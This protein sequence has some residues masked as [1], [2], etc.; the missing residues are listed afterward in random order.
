MADTYYPTLFCLITGLLSTTLMGTY[1]LTAG[2]FDAYTAMIV[3]GALLFYFNITSISDT[4]A[5]ATVDV[6][7]AVWGSQWTEEDIPV[8]RLVLNMMTRAQKPGAARVPIL[9]TVDLPSYKAAMN[10]WYSF[11]QLIR[12]LNG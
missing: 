5:I 11:L 8:R 2:I 1:K 9:G 10:Q 7:D 4:L 12:S 6:G 3:P